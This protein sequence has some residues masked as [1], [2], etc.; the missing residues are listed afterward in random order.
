[1][2]ILIIPAR[3]GSQGIKKKNLQIVNGLTLIERAIRTGLRS[4]ANLIIVST[5]DSE[6]MKI[7]EQ[8]KEIILH[9]RSKKN[10]QNDSSTES[11]LLE[12]INE[13][14]Q[15][16]DIESSIGF[17]QVT[18]PFLS[19]TTINEG[20]E[21]S[22]KK[23]SAFSA[24][25]FHGLVWE[26]SGNWHPVNHP[27]D[28]RPRRQEMTNFVIETGGFYCFP[29]QEFIKSEYRFC[30]LPQPII[31][32]SIHSIEIDE[33]NELHTANLIATQF[34][35]SDFQKFTNIR[36][37]KIIFTDFDGCLTDD[38]VRLN[39]F[40]YESVIVNRKDG[41]AVK[42]LKKLGIDVVIVSMEQNKIVRKR[43]N[44]L[45]IKY[46]N[47]VNDKFRTIS[48]YLNLKNLEWSDCWFLGNEINDLEALEAAEISFCPR[49]AAP[50][51][52]RKAHVVLSRRGGEGLLAEIASKL[53]SLKN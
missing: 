22:K 27:M 18:S 17:M 35:L 6:I 1:M 34:E 3:G 2:N 10:S 15:K 51:V 31:V 20:F 53:E 23:L 48:D 41:L 5:D 32:D 45:S 44:K 7:V 52:F 37:P 29:L 21:L 50:E 30:T 47:G 8:Y 36:I 14:G 46:I 25:S 33:V 16:W 43:A 13:V 19:S 39:V 38:K 4:K 24:S 28:R 49:D 9:K 26:N 12:V 11:V 42:R 40:G